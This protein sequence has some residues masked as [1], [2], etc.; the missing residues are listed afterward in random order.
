M[1]VDLPRSRACTSPLPRVKRHLRW[2]HM[3]P[4]GGFAMVRRLAMIIGL[5]VL[6]APPT[7]AQV[8]V[9]LSAFAGFYLPTNDLFDSVRLRP[10]MSSV[11]ILGLGMEPGPLVGGRVTVRFSRLSVEAEAAYALTRLDMPSVLVDAG[12]EDGASAFLGSVDVLY[13]FY[14][15]AF[16]PLSLYVLGG[17][18][19]VAR[20]GDYLDIFEST[21]DL[22]VVL[23]TGFR[24]GLSPVTYIRF[25]LK[26]YISSYA[27]KA[28]S[29]FQFDSKPQNDLLLTIAVE[30]S[31]SP[32][33]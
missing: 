9:G 31:L 7:Q 25:D 17:L 18:G 19:F 16:S 27:P 4:D 21:T 22:A 33:R 2:Y 13:D 3:Y 24:Y 12:V 6:T 15:A 1:E 11:I 28:R 29:G 5:L 30:L 8:R 26:D 10:D 23:G 20:G 14:Q 32:S